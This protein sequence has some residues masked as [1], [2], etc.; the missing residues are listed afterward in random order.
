MLGNR[1]RRFTRFAGTVMVVMVVL[2]IA[3][4]AAVLMRGELTYDNA[5]QLPGIRAVRDS[6]RRPSARVAGRTRGAGHPV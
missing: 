3:Q 1:E 2:M 4:A 6:D 5:Y